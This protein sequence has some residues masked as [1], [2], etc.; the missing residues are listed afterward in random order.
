M[1]WMNHAFAPIL[2]GVGWALI[3]DESALII[4]LADVYWQ[5]FGDISYLFIGIFALALALVSIL[6]S[7]DHPGKGQTR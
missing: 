4:A 1:A 6:G 5:P 3:L 7:D 2:F